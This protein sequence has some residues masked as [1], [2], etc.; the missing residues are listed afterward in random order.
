VINNTCEGRNPFPGFGDV[1]G[2]IQQYVFYTEQ[3]RKRGIRK[4]E[5]EDP[6]G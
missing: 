1:A 3:M 6:A 2:V 5:I 4:T